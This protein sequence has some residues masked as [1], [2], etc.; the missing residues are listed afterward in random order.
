[1]APTKAS[2][3]L[4][5]FA[6][7]LAPI[8]VV[9]GVRSAVVFST[10]AET[11]RVAW[12][13]TRCAGEADFVFL[14]VDANAIV[15]NPLLT[16]REW[17][18]VAD[19]AV[20]EILDLYVPELAVQ[21]AVARY[22][23]SARTR[24]R[25]LRKQLRRWPPSARVLLEDAVAASD[26]FADGYDRALRER[27]TQMG[28]YIIQYP[29][30]PHEDVA[31]RAIRRGAPFDAEGNGYR[32]ALHWH[33][34]L[35]LLEELEPEDPIAVLLSAD[36]KA[37]GPL[38]HEE[39]LRE[40]EELG[41]E[42]EVD[43]VTHVTDFVVPGQFFDEEQALDY[44]Q[45]TQLERAI[46]ESLLAG[47]WPVDFSSTLARRANYDSAEVAKVLDMHVEELTVRMERRSRD[48]WLTFTANAKCRIRFETVEI[49]DEEVGDFTVVKDVQQWTLEVE[50][51]AYSERSE[52]RSVSAIRLVS[53]E[54]PS[55]RFVP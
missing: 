36:K 47:G 50:G 22:R 19:A 25:E 34:F 14:F 31:M 6:E 23:D 52:I 51:S 16:G 32:D 46:R 21:E 28:A 53:A 40:V 41:V 5:L 9:E 54:S 49:L 24:Q 8:S 1:M 27:L 17:D 35:E 15:S 45:M 55:D 2:A 3:G 26:R 29:R 44:L 4:H 42:W 38:R 13:I 37:F 48:L 20:S 12:A 43:F 10:Q 33:S 7:W 39:L 11:Q 18:A 30:V